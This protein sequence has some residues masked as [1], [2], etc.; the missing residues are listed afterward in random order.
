MPLSLIRKRHFRDSPGIPGRFT[1]AGVLFETCH[2]TP[3]KQSLPGVFAE[4]PESWWC[5]KPHTSVCCS[6]KPCP[7]PNHSVALKQAALL[8]EEPANR[9]S[10]EIKFHNR[11]PPLGK[12]VPSQWAL[13][14]RSSIF[15]PF[16]QKTRRN[17]GLS[18]RE[19]FAGPLK[20]LLAAAAE[21]KVRVKHGGCE[22]KEQMQKFPPPWEPVFLCTCVAFRQRKNVHCEWEA[23]LLCYSKHP[24]QV[25]FI[26]AEKWL[27]SGERA[28]A[29]LGVNGEASW[30]RWVCAPPATSQRPFGVADGEQAGAMVLALPLFTEIHSCGLIIWS[31]NNV[32]PIWWVA[33]CGTPNWWV[34]PSS[35]AWYSQFP[36]LGGSS[37]PLH[38]P[39]SGCLASHLHQDLASW[40]P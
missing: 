33:V 7:I 12:A 21:F 22:G 15:C 29:F 37:T 17:A 28:G 11:C 34:S 18:C 24:F 23:C 10:S 14:G 3:K 26:Q 25:R 19:G 8:N 20:L 9:D 32:S 31:P 4:H 13:P 35:P 36:S 40:T 5:S 6:F 38:S 39:H 2:F 16:G 30:E 27:D 1:F